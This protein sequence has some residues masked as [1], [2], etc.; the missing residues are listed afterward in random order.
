MPVRSLSNT[1]PF[2]EV[3]CKQTIFCYTN[4]HD[5][6][7]L[8]AHENKMNYRSIIKVDEDIPIYE[9]VID[10]PEEGSGCCIIS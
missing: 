4:C 8:I 10:Q 9:W 2:Y 5:H 3:Y 7:M 1:I 6:A